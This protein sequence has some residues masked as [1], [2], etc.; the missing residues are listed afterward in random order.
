MLV[1]TKAYVGGGGY[2]YRHAPGHPSVQGKPYKY[3]LEHR[4][5]MES[6]LGRVLNSWE[7]VHHKD[8]NRQHNDPSNLELW[9][10]NQP[11]G[12]ASEYLNEIVRLRLRVAELE[13]QLT[14]T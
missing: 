3:V 9:V 8:G 1:R 4:L 13:A 5:V 14:A 10:V 12:Q 6:L 2:V 11:A 7:N